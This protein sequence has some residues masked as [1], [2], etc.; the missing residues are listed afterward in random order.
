MGLR[1]GDEVAR[2]DN[3][4]AV[5]RISDDGVEG[6]PTKG[7]HVCHGSNLPLDMSLPGWSLRPPRGV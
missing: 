5:V 4:Y 6:K 7:C 2:G 3:A 1:E